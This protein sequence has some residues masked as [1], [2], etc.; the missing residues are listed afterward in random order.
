MSEASNN[1]VTIF[2]NG[3]A[4]FTRVFK[5]TGE[6]QSV[7][8]PV[9]KD[10]IGDIL[11]SLIVSGPVKL[12]VPPCFIP[13]NE[14]SGKLTLSQDNVFQDIFH[15]LRGAEVEIEHGTSGEPLKGR[16]WG[17]DSEEVASGG[18]ATN[19]YYGQVLTS[20]GLKRV[21]QS[22]VKSL[23]FPQQSVQSEV[24]KALQREFQKI[25]PQST[26]VNLEVTSEEGGK[27]FF[28]RYTVPAAAWKMTYRLRD[29]GAGI[30]FDG[31]GVVDN[32]TEE[33]WN[34]FLVGL[35]VGEPITFSTDVATS[36]TP[37]RSNVNLVSDQAQGAVEVE[38][39][40]AARGVVRTASAKS[41]RGGPVMAAAMSMD[42]DYCDESVESF[43][44]GG[45]EMMA[46]PAM[47]ADAGHR[48]VGDF[49]VFEF[50]SPLTIKA[51][52]SAEIPVFNSELEEAD[53][54][55]FYKPENHIERPFRAIRF[56]NETDQNL[57]RGV[58][59]VYDKGTYAGSAVLNAT[60]KGEKA[61]LCHALET[62]VRV[63][64]SPGN[65]EQEVAS[66][67]IAKGVVFQTNNWQR[68]SEYVIKNVKDEEFTLVL[69]HQKVWDK[70]GKLTCLLGDGAVEPKEQLRNGVRFEITVPANEEVVLSVTENFTQEQKLNLNE[71]WLV[72]SIIRT[73]HPLL[74]EGSIQAILELQEGL[75]DRRQEEQELV[76]RLNV[77]TSEQTRIR[78]LIDSDP[79]N[80]DWKGDLRSAE[81]EIRQISREKLPAKKKEVQEAQ[82]AVTDALKK[83]A[84][85]WTK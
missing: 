63:K 55:L 54:V 24:D 7:E 43:G 78:G 23:K 5:T 26:T 17:L 11:A 67:K 13:A 80:E 50:N 8:I 29:T 59:T 18:E 21:L 2:S 16:I 72:N 61:L 51:G 15:K 57:G 44:G 70:N 69:D 81:T 25:R 28:L 77:V 74:Q 83:L 56:T 65:Q 3:I 34:E 64:F 53:S 39:G 62:G 79:N 76:D 41:M 35:V 45:L 38:R 10:H 4:D 82:K 42:A 85:E 27:E 1:R 36:K 84:C 71:N 75:A 48:E 60:K 58:C 14:Q 20:T 31:V 68:E 49:S 22:E 9:N 46:A 12:T 47:E 30:A 52:Q 33:D 73:E 37:N 19:R 66:L 40:Y 32:N 6:A